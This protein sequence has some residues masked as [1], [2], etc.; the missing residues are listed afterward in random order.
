MFLFLITF[1]LFNFFGII[2]KGETIHVPILKVL[3]LRAL[4]LIGSFERDGKDA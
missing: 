4:E 3:Q 2:V 1:I